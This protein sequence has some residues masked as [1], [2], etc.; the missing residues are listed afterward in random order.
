MTFV[1]M[2]S[3]VMA[4]LVYYYCWFKSACKNNNNYIE[5]LMMFEFNKFFQDVFFFDR[6]KNVMLSFDQ[7][8]RDFIED[9]CCLKAVPEYW[10]RW[11]IGKLDVTV[12]FPILHHLSSVQLEFVEFQF[13]MVQLLSI[14]MLKFSATR[15]AYET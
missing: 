9:W 4:D 12:H 13:L 11:N 8:R 15:N 14:L 10:K 5:L 3:D 6:L 1:T 7:M 2:Y